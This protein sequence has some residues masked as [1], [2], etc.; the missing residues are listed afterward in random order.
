MGYA[1]LMAT[2]GVMVGIGASFTGLGGGFLMVPIVAELIPH[3]KHDE[4][5]ARE[6][7]RQTD[8]IDEGVGGVL[9]EIP[10]CNC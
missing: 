3:E 4:D 7:Y 8:N 5:E 10:K 1:A 2:L 9:A 6:P